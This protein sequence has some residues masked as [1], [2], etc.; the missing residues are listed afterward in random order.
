MGNK[1]AILRRCLACQEQKEKK[2]LIRIVK[3][4]EEEL[5]IDL[6]RKEKW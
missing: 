2:E 6:S 4:K 3:P 5:Q 1:K